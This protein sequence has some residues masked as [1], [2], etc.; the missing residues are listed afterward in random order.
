[1][2][3]AFPQKQRLVD[4]KVPPLVDSSATVYLI[5]E[6]KNAKAVA[7]VV[8][9]LYGSRQSLAEVLRENQIYNQSSEGCTEDVRGR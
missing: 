9:K 2:I 1:M 7:S 3:L 8:E 5:D 6:I 4:E